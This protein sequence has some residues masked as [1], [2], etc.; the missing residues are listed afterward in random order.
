LLTGA[1]VSTSPAETKVK[2]TVGAGGS[3]E[4]VADA[5]GLGEAGAEPAT[6]GELL[7]AAVFALPVPP[8]NRY[9]S[10]NARAIPST[11]ASVNHNHLGAPRWG[12]VE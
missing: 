6:L 7:G 3:A 4:G 2:F 9:E 12:V 8:V 5:S 10:A 11:P 1:W